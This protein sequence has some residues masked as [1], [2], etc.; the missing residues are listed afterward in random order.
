M[1]PETL[2]PQLVRDKVFL[3]ELYSSQS[4]PNSKRLL[5]F[6]SDSK[7]NTIIK[8]LHFVANGQIKVKREH[9]NEIPKRLVTLLRKEFERK[10]SMR[11]LIN[12]ERLSK[13]KILLK[14][15]TLSIVQRKLNGVFSS[16]KNSK[17]KT[18]TL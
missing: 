2:K 5:N 11:S 6:A 12:N 7:L 8:F 10:T 16:E 3:E 4:V 14:I 17:F 9:F 15:F 13:L 1:N 18:F